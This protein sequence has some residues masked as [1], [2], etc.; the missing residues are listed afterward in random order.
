MIV[1]G[2]GGEHPG[3]MRQ[4]DQLN[5]TTVAAPIQIS[6]C[7]ARARGPRLDCPGAAHHFRAREIEQRP[8]FRDDVDRADFLSRLATLSG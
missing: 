3:T 4:F 5:V 6:Q 8:I 7:I 1:S 2:A